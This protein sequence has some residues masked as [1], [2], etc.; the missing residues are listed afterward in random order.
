MTEL[1]DLASAQAL[2]RLEL[3][4]T[5]RLEGLLHGEH[6]GL[7]PGVGSEVAEAREYRPGEDD[8]R[9]MDW[10]VTARTTVPHVRDLLA[11]HELVTTIVLD[12]SASMDFGTVLYEKRDVALGAVAAF[13]LMTQRGGNRVGAYVSAPVPLRWPARPGRHALMGL[14]AR[15]IDLPRVPAGAA[16]SSLAE[17]V[18][19]GDSQA[20]RRGLVV[21]VSDF[22]D[23]DVEEW[24][25]ALRRVSARH[26]LVAV[27]VVDPRELELPDV[28]MLAL[29]DPETGRTR[30]VWTGDRRLRA[31]YAAA[32]AEQRALVAGGI[33]GSGARHLQLRTDRDWVSDIARFAIATRRGAAYSRPTP[34]S[35]RPAAVGGVR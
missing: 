16:K 12:A 23:P 30:D 26:E 19:A 21:V 27:E 4:V 24:G 6:I 1:R 32:A 33:R 11:D 14:L 3:T 18:R 10:A 9:R 29:V 22:L 35:S 8:V 2:R 15:V 28:G 25:R 31:R 20:R 5:R 17:V 34:D 7:L 13:G